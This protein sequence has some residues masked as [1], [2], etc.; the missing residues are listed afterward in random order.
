MRLALWLVSHK[1]MG[2]LSER[3]AESVFKMVGRSVPG[4]IHLTNSPSLDSQLSVGFRKDDRNTTVPK[5]KATN[6]IMGG[7]GQAYCLII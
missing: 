2:L 7:A 6:C 5:Q 3:P 1:K 4:A